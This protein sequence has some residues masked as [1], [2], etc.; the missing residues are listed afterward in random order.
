VKPIT[1]HIPYGLAYAAAVLMECAWK[2][3]R[4][5]TRPLLTTYTVK[6]LGSRLR[7]SISKAKHE[8]QWEPPCTF[9]EGFQETMKWLKTCDLTKLKTK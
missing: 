5:Q 8:L 3:F 7:F 6:N 9:E 2:L 1:T 4:M